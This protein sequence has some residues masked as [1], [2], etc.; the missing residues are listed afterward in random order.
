MLVGYID[1]IYSAFD[2]RLFITAIK[3]GNELLKMQIDA[4]QEVKHPKSNNSESD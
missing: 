2:M 1:R 3:H 4:L